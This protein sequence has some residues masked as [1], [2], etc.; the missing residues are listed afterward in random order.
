MKY[1]TSC[2]MG[3][4]KIFT[5]DISLFFDN[6]IGDVTTIVEVHSKEP[7][8]AMK[9]HFSGHFTVKNNLAYLSS[10]DC[11]DD[12]IHTFKPGRWFVMREHTKPHFHIYHCDMDIHA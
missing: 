3:V 12:P 6:G 5:D 11:E 10:Y 2:N 8:G 7:A 9:M 4:I 1:E